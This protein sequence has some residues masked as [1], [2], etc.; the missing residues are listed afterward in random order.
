MNI[1]KFQKKYTIS[2]DIFKFQWKKITTPMHAKYGC[3]M[4]LVEGKL[5]EDI[6]NQN[7][8]MKNQI[9]IQHHQYH[10]LIKKRLSF[11]RAIRR[12]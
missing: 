4:F 9:Y 7:V 6:F 10:I 11:Y 12:F 5:R 3:I 2:I 8:Y 1:K